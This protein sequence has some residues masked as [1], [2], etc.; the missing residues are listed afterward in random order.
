MTSTS[1][2]FNGLFGAASGLALALMLYSLRLKKRRKTKEQQ[3]GVVICPFQPYKWI[4]VKHAAKWVEEG[5]ERHLLPNLWV[6]Q[7]GLKS[8]ASFGRE[9]MGRHFPQKSSKYTWLNHGSYGAACQEYTKCYEH[10]KTIFSRHPDEFMAEVAIPEMA[11]VLREL[12]EFVNCPFGDL[13]FVP[14]ATN[15]VNA[16]VS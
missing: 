14:N 10:Y 4:G 16:V 8:F 5:V 1:A 7:D 11:D 6:P 2:G 3:D 15:G 13:V 9:M 12:S